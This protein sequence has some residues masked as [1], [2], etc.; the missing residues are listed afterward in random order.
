M[1]FRIYCDSGGFS[2]ELGQLEKRGIIEIFHYP[3]ESRNS[4]IKNKALPSEMRWGDM[5]EPWGKEFYPWKDYVGSEKFDELVRMLNIKNRK[6][7]LHLD[8]AYI[9]NCHFFVTSDK[10][11]IFSSRNEISRLLNI[12]VCLHTDLSP[13]TKAIEKEGNQ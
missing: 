12:S 10:G 6:D 3:Y 8:S 9:T 1:K 13:I 4:K 7:A 5:I 11:D 2:K